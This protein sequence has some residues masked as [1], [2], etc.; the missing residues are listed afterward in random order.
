MPQITFTPITLA[1]CGCCWETQTRCSLEKK[2]NKNMN[3]HRRIG[4]AKTIRPK[5]SFFVSQQ[6]HKPYL[7]KHVCFLMTFFKKNYLA[8]IIKAFN[9]YCPVFSFVKYPPLST[10]YFFFLTMS[11]YVLLLQAT[12]HFSIPRVMPCVNLQHMTCCV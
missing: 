7:L 1:T 2:H 3:K 5:Q 4:K 11:F 10:Y 9:I 8:T 12:S 6:T